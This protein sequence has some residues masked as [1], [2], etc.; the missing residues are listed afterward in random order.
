[1][2]LLFIAYLIVFY[3]FLMCYVSYEITE[4]L[5]F[6]FHRHGLSNMAPC[7]SSEVHSVVSAIVVDIEDRGRQV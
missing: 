3:F 4:I 2:A 1:M 5:G 7:L 6:H